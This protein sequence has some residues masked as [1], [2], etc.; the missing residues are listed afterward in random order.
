MDKVS[1]RKSAMN[2]V[3]WSMGDAALHGIG[4]SLVPASLLG[5]THVPGLNCYLCLRT[6][7]PSCPTTSPNPIATHNGMVL[8]DARRTGAAR[9]PDSLPAGAGGLRTDAVGNE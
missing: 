6:V 1:R 7:P 2:W 8:I 9:R 5:V 4:T 3:R